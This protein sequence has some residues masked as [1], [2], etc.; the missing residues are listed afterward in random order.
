MM[1][2]GILPTYEAAID[3]MY[4]S[5]LAQRAAE[6]GL[7]L[8]GQYGGLM[9]GSRSVPLRGWPAFYYLDTVSYSIMAG[10]SEI[11]RNV[12]ATRGLGLPTR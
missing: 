6:F 1:E 9:P 12:I 2:K 10:T 3:K 5:E 7:E 4:N 8:L 11:D